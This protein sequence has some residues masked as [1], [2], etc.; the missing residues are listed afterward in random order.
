M[1]RKGLLLTVLVMMMMIMAPTNSRAIQTVIVK[2]PSKEKK[3]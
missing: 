1:A 3:R 2:Y